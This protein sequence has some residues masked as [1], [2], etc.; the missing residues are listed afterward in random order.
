MRFVI[1]IG[2]VLEVH[3][4]LTTISYDPNITDILLNEENWVD[5]NGS[6]FED[7]AFEYIVAYREY[8]NYRGGWFTPAQMAS[9]CIKLKER[10]KRMLTSPEGL[11]W[12]ED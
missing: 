1:P 7:T 2:P 8:L 12:M 5:E 10:L 4:G 11:D 9:R 3:F 6:L